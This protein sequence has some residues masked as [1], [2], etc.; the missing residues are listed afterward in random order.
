[1]RGSHQA[2]GV[3]RKLLL[4][5]FAVAALAAANLAQPAQAQSSAK[6]HEDYRGNPC[7]GIEV[8]SGIGGNKVCTTT[9]IS[10]WGEPTP[11]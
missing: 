2:P 9:V 6:C 3:L 1:M 7:K 4:A 10:Y 5:G 11:R 8:C